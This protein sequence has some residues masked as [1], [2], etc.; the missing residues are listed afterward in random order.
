MNYVYY[1]TPTRNH[2]VYQGNYKKCLEHIKN[3]MNLLYSWGYFFTIRDFKG[4]AL[5]KVG[6]QIVGMKTKII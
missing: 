4:I 6:S 5:K 1:N 2:L 3:N